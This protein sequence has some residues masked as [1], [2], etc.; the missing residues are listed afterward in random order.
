MDRSDGASVETPAIAIV[1]G[2]ASGIGLAT[3]L[4]LLASPETLVAAADR[5]PLPQTLGDHADRVLYLD[6]DV[7]DPTQVNDAV[8]RTVRE[9][10]VPTMLVNSAGIQQYFTAL[11]LPYE[12]FERVL[13]VNLGGTFLFCQAAGKH[14][15]AA[16]CGAIVNLA[17][18]SA[19]FGFPSRLPYIVSKCGVIGLT[20]VLAVEWAHANVRVNAVA[21]GMVDTPFVALAFDEGV[22]QRDKAEKA[23][24]LG[25]LGTPEEVADAITFLLSDR[26]SFITGEVLCVDGGFRRLK[27]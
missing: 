8:E 10:G 24:A 5:H 27:I 7:T 18:I 17:S 11:E 3:A 4:A 19:Y 16:G 20:Q 13:R 2:A 6:V 9:L 12:E 14:M 1:T 22:V 25:R 21:P 15:V 26:A 23:H